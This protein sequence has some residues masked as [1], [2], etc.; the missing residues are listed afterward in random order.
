[1]ALTLTPTMMLLI[2]TVTDAAITKLFL[3][4]EGKTEAEIDQMV[5]EKMKEKD[6]LDARMAGH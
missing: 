3:E 4:L 6:E 1:M 5:A 2:Q